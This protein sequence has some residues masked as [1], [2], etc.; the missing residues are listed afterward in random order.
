MALVDP[1]MQ[2]AMNKSLFNVVK[3]HSVQVDQLELKPRSTYS[4]LSHLMSEVGEL[5]QE[6]AVA[7]GDHYKSHSTD[8]IVGEAVDVLLCALDLI[9]AHDPSIT[10]KD[11]VA[12]ATSKGTKWVTAVTKQRCEVITRESIRTSYELFNRLTGDQA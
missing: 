7:Q 4:V 12:I 1:C 11:L 3:E 8:H 10:E 6:V 5:A 9:H 2:A